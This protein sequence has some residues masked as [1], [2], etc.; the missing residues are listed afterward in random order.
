V[1]GGR[2]RCED[3]PSQMPGRFRIFMRALHERS[4]G[5]LR[6]VGGGL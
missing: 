6:P 4:G 1:P 3:R 5:A 2:Q